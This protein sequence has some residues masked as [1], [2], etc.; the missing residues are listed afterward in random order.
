MVV[1]STTGFSLNDPII[2]TELT[3][4]LASSN[5]ESGRTYYV[6]QIVSATEMTIS[7]LVNG[8][9]LALNNGTGS[10]TLTN[11][12]NTV[13]LDTATGSMTM[14]VSLPVSPGQLNGQLFTVYETAGQYPD[15]VSEDYSDLIERTIL[16]TIGTN[17]TVPVNRLSVSESEGGTFNFY[18]NM[19]LRISADMGNL[20]ENQTYYVTEYSGRPLGTNPQTYVP[21]IQVEVNTTSSSGNSII[22]AYD[23]LRNLYGTTSL[24]VGM[25]IEFSGIGL[26][27]IVIG[28]EYFIES[29][30]SSTEFTISE[31]DGGAVKTLSTANGIMMGTGTPFITVSTSKGGSNVSLA[32]DNSTLS[33]FTQYITQTSEF[34]LSYVLGG[35]TALITDPGE[36]FA[37]NNVI[38]IPGTAVDGVIPTNN[39]T[40]TVNSV[41]TDGGITSVIRTGTPP[42]T[43]YQ[44]YFQVRSEDTVAVYSNPLM[45]VPVSGIDFPAIGYTESIATNSTTDTLTVNTTGFSNYDAV[46]FSGTIPTAFDI[47]TTYYLYNVTPTTAQVTTVPNDATTLVSGITFLA[48]FT[49][50]KLGS[51]ALL[52]EPF[53]FN[54]SIV[55]FN[56][57]VYECVISNNDD[58]FI[59]GKW[60]L[61]DSGD[62]RLNAM[63]RVLGYYQPTVDM[64][65]VDLTQLFEG[66]TYPNSTYLGNAFQPDQQY[67][68]DTILQDTPFYP[69]E[70]D[71][72]GIVY[73]GEKYIT[74]A[75]LPTYSAIVGSVDNDNWAVG[76]LTNSNINLTDIVY[77]GGIYLMT[78]ANPS[79]PI[80]RSADGLVWTTTGYY[81]PDELSTSA[82]SIAALSLTSASYCAL[83]QAWVAVGQDIIRSTDSYMWD[84]VT[85][86]NPAYDYQLN[87]VA[88][89]TGTNCMGLVAVG[90]GKQPDYSTGVTQ[91]VDINLF[92]YSPNSTTWSQ[93]PAITN[94]GFYGVASDGSTVISVGENGVIYYTQN[95]IDWV[96]L[97]EVTC[98]FVNSSTNV[99]SVTNTAGFTAGASGTPVRFSNSFSTIIAGTTYYVKSIVS[100]TQITLSDTLD[101]AVK[102]LVSITAG[103]FVNGTTYTITSIGT[104]DFTLIGAASNTVGVTFTA[105]GPG[106]GTG[107]ANIVRG[108]I[109]PPQTLMY[110]YN[111]LDP[112]P[113]TLRSIIYAGGVWVAVGDSGTIKTSVNGVTWT[114]RTSGITDTLNNIAYNSDSLTFTV[115]GDNNAILAS[116]DAGVT[117]SYTSVLTPIETAYDVTGADFAFGY[118]PE[119][120]VAG[121][122][123]DTIAMTVTTRPGTNWPVAEYGHTGFEVVSL[124]LVPTSLLQTEYSFA[125]AVKVPAHVNVQVINRTTKLGASLDE[126]E[127][128]IDWVNKTITLDNPL[129]FSPAPDTLRIDVYAVGNGD[130]LIKSSTDSTPIRISSLTG[131]NE[132]F[133][134]AN[135]SASI[136]EGSGVLRPGTDNINVRVFET[137]SITD[138]ILCDSVTDFVLNGPITF[139]G[140]PFGGLQEETVY[141][142][143]SISFATNA[144]VISPVYDSVT[145]TAGPALELTDATGEMF[146]NIQNGA[147]SV[148]TDPIVDHNGTKLVFGSTGLVTRSKSS[149]NALTVG[150]TS[151]L[152]AGTPITFGQASFGVLVPFQRYFIKT[153]VDGN[154]FTISETLGGPEVTLTN[155]NGTTTYVTNDYAVGQRSGNKASLIFATNQYNTDDD[156]I[157]FSLFGETSPVQ[158]GYALPEVQYYNG[159]GSTA[160][161]YLDNFVG[162]DNP[163]NAIVEIDGVRITASQYTISS[164]SNTILFNSPPANGTAISVMTY[165][166]TSRQYFTSQYN[167][168]GNPG[169]SLVSLTVGSTT[170][171]EAT[172]DQDTPTAISYDQDTPTVV[173]YDEV[174]DYLTLS[175]GN[176]SALTVN[177]SIIFTAP[178]IGGIVAGQTYYVVDII[179]STDFVISEEVGGLPFTLTTAS[180][181]MTLQ[182][183]GLTVAPISSI[184]N[185]ISPPLATTIA[186]ESSAANDRITVDSTTGFV[187]N[188]PV[189]FFGTSFDA[190][191]ETDGTVYFVQSIVSSTQFTL[192]DTQ[193][194]ALKPLAGGGP[195]AMQVVVGGNPTT[196]ITTSIENNLVENT[197]VR[198]DGTI[199]STQLNGNTYYAKIISPYTFDIYSQPYTPN[200]INYPITTVSAYTGGGYA[201]RQGLFF[202]VTTTA[203]A[204]TATTNLI[205]VGSTEDLIV[206]TP[207]YFS[208]VETPN[209]DINGDPTELM[210]GLEQGVVYYVKTIEPANKI[211]VSAIRYGE[212]VTLTTDTGSINITQ[213]SQTNVDR[214]WVT[215]NGYRVPSSNLRVSNF[216]EVSILSR[217]IPGDQ[218][219]IT[220]MI[221]TSTPDEDIYINFVNQLNEGSVYRINPNITTWLTQSVYPLS[222]TIYVDDITNVTRQVVQNVTAPSTVAGFYYMGLTADKNLITGVTVRN[223]TKT[224]IMIPQNALSVEVI[225]LTPTLKIVP[226]AYITAGDSLTIT[227]LEGNTIYINGEEIRFGS[228][229]FANNALTEISR[230][231]NGT[232]SQPFIPQYSKVY[233]LLSSNRLTDIYY[234]QEWN[235]YVYNTIEGDPLQISDTVP[236]DFLNNENT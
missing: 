129:A 233:G 102:Q 217:I 16:A 118:A 32:N 142:I 150:T 100:S 21:N 184:I 97:N 81:T 44:Y 14:N 115:V 221:P 23:A 17:Y 197:L 173:A 176:T 128:T 171:E 149:N 183:N 20:V 90:K 192:S 200:G 202:T 223:N 19:P 85:S 168:T 122:V 46:S 222:E 207:I 34:D 210:G 108:D 28:Q 180:G 79:T 196:R 96:G 45:T 159:D 201:W 93:A 194:G 198:I 36:G 133:V 235:S 153:I 158:Y 38:T 12:K 148:W 63:D 188:Q 219:I 112:N 61:L 48:N 64:P 1:E 69:T 51:I 181:S 77:A 113:A 27:G 47:G 228:V 218:V 203:T 86:F 175:S 131:F 49:M 189:Q 208:Q 55:K 155:F 166:D 106:A 214:L 7:Q 140:V 136:F 172:F 177:D 80:Y 101:G 236:A 89:I 126:T 147:G 95:G 82:L 162:Y 231:V 83:G 71:I 58:E 53:Y 170:H 114:T 161:F 13:Q 42:A 229:D 167:I 92:F 60:E 205:T 99:L 141:F 88:P 174:L 22:C 98:E 72:T 31:T 215:I 4:T 156:Y 209:F 232:A 134:N 35:Y 104:T 165:N 226:G 151:G 145:G 135:Y 187:V 117:W 119:E 6:S 68:I 230:G 111:S 116:D 157:V 130:Q 62:R 78:S 110:Q 103:G 8:T 26:G 74:S 121:V 107:T 59:F 195:S 169:S 234:N 211:T 39:I 179:D 144:I 160:S 224:G 216:N 191:I 182:A 87:S 2:I 9:V 40:L 213:W 193:G 29:I 66:V 41:N 164:I 25:P 75:N 163:T 190:D 73:D 120:L 132:I 154:E 50:A 18:V 186:T 56:N 105:T 94:K 24:Y 225:E 15:I 76:R 204:T 91:L 127:Y 178:T 43:S 212:A 206:G 67:P 185:S 220:N 70:V 199:G 37:V 227:T 3:D 5:I 52:P 146:S 65:G 125:D 152:I 33:V 109:I 84:K 143:K 138:R 10:A 57:R 30:T 124:E 123:S 137:E 11:Q 139:Q 54:Q